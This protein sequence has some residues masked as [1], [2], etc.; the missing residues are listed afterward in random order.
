MNKE[1]GTTKFLIQA[2]LKQDSPGIIQIRIREKGGQR[3]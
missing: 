3:Y 2:D 1:E